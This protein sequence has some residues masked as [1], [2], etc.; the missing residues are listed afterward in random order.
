MDFCIKAFSEDDSTK[1]SRS[2]RKCLHDALINSE[3]MITKLSTIYPIKCSV[4][5]FLE[6]LCAMMT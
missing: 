4:Y 5:Y 3:N 2:F 1:L 6:Y